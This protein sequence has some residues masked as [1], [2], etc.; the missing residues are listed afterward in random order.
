MTQHNVI[1][2]QRPRE[3]E[4]TDTAVLI[5]E[6]IEPYTAE[7]DGHEIEGYKYDYTTYTKDEYIL[8]LAQQN[9]KL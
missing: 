4:I 3:I 8:L 2:M 6:N 5:A 1:G 7:Q 9:I